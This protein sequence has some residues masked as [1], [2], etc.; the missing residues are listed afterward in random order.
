MKP[1]RPTQRIRVPTVD[2]LRG[3]AAL[4]VC[5]F[6]LTNGNELFLPAGFLKLSGQYGWAGVQVFFV[7]SGFIIPLT[8]W[9]S[10]Y[11]LK[12]YARFILK[13]VI[14]LD[15]PYLLSLLLVLALAYLTFFLSGRAGK[16]PGYSLTQM[17]FHLGFLNAFFGYEW[18]NVV[19]WTLAV[20]FQYYLLIGLVFPL[21]VHDKAWIKLS[22]CGLLLATGALIPS[23]QFVFA[24]LP[25]FLLGIFTFYYR[26]E[27][28][29]KK[30]ACAG[31]A[32][33]AFYLC[34]KVGALIAAVAMLTSV[35]ILWAE[36]NHKLLKLLGDISYSLYLIHVPIGVR[37]INLSARYATSMPGKLLSLALALGLTLGLSYLFY[38]FIELPS[39]QWSSGISY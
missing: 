37:I 27:L 16:P 6:H 33:L 4:S 19:Y 22:A 21:L 3:L 14:R 20:E 31:L 30:L 38:R 29:D 17:V 39:R 36:I 5:W 28:L 34:Y 1:D 10:G 7:I 26:A 32:M 25:L 15:P 35:L 13:R 11:K 18:V 12:S 24:W 9:Q 8:L 2:A 23:A